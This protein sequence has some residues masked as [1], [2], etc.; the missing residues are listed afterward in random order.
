MADSRPKVVIVSNRLGSF[1]GGER[2]VCEMAARLKEKLELNIINP[3]SEKDVVR[4][5]EERLSKLFNIKDV[6]I[7]RLKCLGVRHR[8]HGNIDLIVLL[9]TLRGLAAL[10]DAV[11]NSDVVYEL[12]FNPFILLRENQDYASLV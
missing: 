11:A 6:R 12:S 9:P 5:D 2:W 10:N 3:I 1:G 8:L 4:M 7:T